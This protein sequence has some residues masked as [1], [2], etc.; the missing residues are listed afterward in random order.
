M[1]PRV[2]VSPGLYLPIK[3]AEA[4]KDPTLHCGISV[5][6]AATVFKEHDGFVLIFGAKA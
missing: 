2:F 1:N 6:V 4:V 3:I 5:L